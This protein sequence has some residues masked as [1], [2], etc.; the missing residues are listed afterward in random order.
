VQG[1][2]APANESA[3]CTIEDASRGS[4]GLSRILDRTALIGMASNCSSQTTKDP[5]PLGSLGVS[6]I[7]SWWR[8]NICEMPLRG[9]LQDHIAYSLEN[10]T[11]LMRLTGTGLCKTSKTLLLLP[12]VV[13]LTLQ[14]DHH[15]S[16]PSS[17]TEKTAFCQHPDAWDEGKCCVFRGMCSHGSAGMEQYGVEKAIPLPKPAD[18]IVRKNAVSK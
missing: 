4:R 13:S 6:N 1:G 16:T 17:C 18:Y 15:G 7:F 11:F 9:T 12:L 8:S 2:P 3:I 14:Y 10:V 5:C